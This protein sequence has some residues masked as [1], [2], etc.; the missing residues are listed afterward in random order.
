MR[1]GCLLVVLFLMSLTQA[2]GQEPGLISTKIELSVG[3]NLMHFATAPSA[4]MAG[5]NVTGQYKWANWFGLA[6]EFD[7][8]FGTGTAART[9]LCGPEIS[10]PRQRYSPFAHIMIGGARLSQK[11]SSDAA[12]A[13]EVGGGIVMSVEG[14][15]SWKLAEFDYVPTYFHNRRQD[16]FRFGTGLVFRF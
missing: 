8:G 2:S 14:K 7:A 11:T 10:I 1:Y 15:I 16:N 13:T 4:N 12:F 9:I 3:S 5:V 6:G